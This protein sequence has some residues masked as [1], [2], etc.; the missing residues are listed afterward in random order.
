MP[1]TA[2]ANKPDES[3][4]DKDK[5]GKGKAPSKSKDLSHVPCKFFRV[6]GCTAGPA[7]PFSHHVAEPG[8]T[9]SVCTWFVKGSCKFGHKCALA[10]VLPGQPMSMDKRNKRAAQTTTGKSGEKGGE[11]KPAD[12]GGA[13]QSRERNRRVGPEGDRGAKSRERKSTLLGTPPPGIGIG[14]KAPITI[15]KAAPTPAALSGPAMTDDLD[16]LTATP[17]QPPPRQFSPVASI[18]APLPDPSS[19]QPGAFNGAQSAA[20]PNEPHR[21]PSPLPLSRPIGSSSSGRLSRNN[22][23]VD[24]GPVGS[25]PAASPGK[26]GF[27]AGHTTRTSINGFTAGTSPPVRGENPAPFGSSPFSAPGSRSLFLSYSLDQHDPV[28]QPAPSDSKWDKQRTIK[29]RD[30]DNAVEDEDLEEFLPSSLTDLLS[31]GERERRMSRTRHGA[32]PSVDLFSRSVPSSNMLDIKSIWDEQNRPRGRDADSSLPPNSQMRGTSQG[33][34]GEEDARSTSSSLTGTSNISA[35]FLGQR[36]AGEPAG[37]RP[38]AAQSYDNNAPAVPDF[39]LSASIDP[40]ST[41]GAMQSRPI[42]GVQKPD[43]SSALS[44]STRAL[45]NHAPGQSLPQGLAA[46]LSRLHLVPAASGNGQYDWSPDGAR[47]GST[48]RAYDPFSF[49]DQPRFSTLN[50][51]TSPSP[52]GLPISRTPSSSSNTALSPPANQR[53]HHGHTWASPLTRPTETN[54]DDDLFAMDEA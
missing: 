44:P 18:A 46:G 50:N 14:S 37:M 47:F 36:P 33:R 17:R 41:F 6:G 54:D 12:K 27:I 35:G 10:H 8:E 53:L 31:P 19:S 51:L 13:S 3:A 52:S 26:P 43:L 9:K 2:P 42:P 40:V 24:F 16:E 34:Y 21:R 23:S 22:P 20:V 38:M 7:C 39:A 11:T 15:S 1:T 28:R 4:T 30:L 5:N 29:P 32:R 45:R 49:E 48:P 25:P